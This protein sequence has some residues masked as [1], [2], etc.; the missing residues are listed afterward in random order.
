MHFPKNPSIT[1]VRYEGRNI[2]FIPYFPSDLKFLEILQTKLQYIAEFPKSLKRLRIQWTLLDT[3]PQ[4][5]EGLEELIIINRQ[6]SFNLTSFPTTLKKLVIIGSSFVSKD[7]PPLPLSLEVLI[8]ESYENH[9]QVQLNVQN[10]LNLKKITYKLPIL[11]NTYKLILPSN[12][13][14]V[15]LRG[16]SIENLPPKIKYLD[17]QETNTAQLP[18]L[19]PKLKYL[20]CSINPITVLPSLPKTL[21]YLNCSTTRISEIQLLPKTLTSFRA[22][23]TPIRFYPELPLG[24]KHVSLVNNF[25]HLMPMLLHSYLLLDNNYEKYNRFIS[26]IKMFKAKYKAK[27]LRKEKKER[28]GRFIANWIYNQGMKPGGLFAKMAIKRAQHNNAKLLELGK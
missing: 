19:P 6:K 11:S 18:S 23:D 8:F 7:L 16:I 24:L 2:K 28:M 20:N 14:T 10:L 5:P 3:L 15:I 9:S 27:I 22:F 1:N 26:T 4:L 13:E 25:T 21:E 12:I 17:I